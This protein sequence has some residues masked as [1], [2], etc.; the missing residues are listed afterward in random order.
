MKK[1]FV[2]SLVT[3]CLVLPSVLSFTGCGG[4]KISELDWANFMHY[5]PY[6]PTFTVYECQKERALTYEFDI[7]EVKDI[8]EGKG[9]Y[10]INVSN[11]YEG[12]SVENL[13]IN[14]IDVGYYY[15]MNAENEEKGIQYMARP[16]NGEWYVADGNGDYK[17][18]WNHPY[19]ETPDGTEAK[20]TSPAFY[21]SILDWSKYNYS[22]FEKAGETDDTVTYVVKSDSLSAVTTLCQT[23]YSSSTVS[24]MSLIFEKDVYSNEG[25]S[26][27]STAPYCLDSISVKD[28]NGLLFVM[29]NIDTTILEKEH[30]LAFI[31][32]KDKSNFTL[33]GGEG[34]DYGEYYFTKDAIRVCT[35]NNPNKAQ[36]EFYLVADRA[37]NTAKYIVK[38]EQ[39]T[40][41][42]QNITIEQFE[43]RKQNLI[44]VYF[45]GIITKGYGSF[46]GYVDYTNL[47]VNPT[48][49]WL[50]DEIQATGLGVAV[51]YKNVNIRFNYH[52]IY[53][54][55]LNIKE[56]SF[57]YVLSAGEQSVTHHFKLTDG[58]TT[59]VT[60]PQV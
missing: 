41:D 20:L 46:K 8:K 19:R 23:V 14:S 47:N 60:V 16:K 5:Y 22:A 55:E 58:G 34:V 21:A 3:A 10:Y 53:G 54:Q 52:E 6:A 7:G 11:A 43:S 17:S 49:I 27:E 57:D 56:A 28:Q 9:R 30:E 50:A 59:T 44:D 15:N 24:G 2:A 31:S 26:Q 35:P 38:T 25:C 48:L 51:T 4:A 32:F 29:K 18:V 33:K 39:G 36:R 37:N 42:V 40:W 45:D 13:K 1:K 12:D